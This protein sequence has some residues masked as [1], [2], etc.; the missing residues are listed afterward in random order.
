VKS[1][2]AIW[3]KVMAPP[4]PADAAPQESSA[5]DGAPPAS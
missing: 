5:S 3:D 4:A 2:Q 1:L